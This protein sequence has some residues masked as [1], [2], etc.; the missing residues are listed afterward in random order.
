LH[1]LYLLHCCSPPF[2]IVPLIDRPTR[3]LANLAK[4]SRSSSIRPRPWDT[5]NVLL[6]FAQFERERSSERVRDKIAASRRKGKWTGGSVPL[7][8][9]ANAIARALD[10]DPLKLMAILLSGGKVKSP[11]TRRN[12]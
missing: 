2:R 7:G 8:Y 4:L 5:L 1:I 6:S 9:D 10:V 12:T 3:S 11:R